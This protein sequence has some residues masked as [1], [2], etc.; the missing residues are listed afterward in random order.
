[1]IYSEIRS[2]MDNDTRT[3]EELLD[4]IARRISFLSSSPVADDQARQA[5]LRLVALFQAEIGLN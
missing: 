5:A 3:P 4:F 1:M 2:L